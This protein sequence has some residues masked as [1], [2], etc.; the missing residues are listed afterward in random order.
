M[1]FTE[2][3]LKPTLLRAL[4]RMKYQEL[5]PIQEQTLPYILAGQD[6]LATAET[7]AGKTGYP[8]TLRSSSSSLFH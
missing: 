4:E 3:D 1:K 5:T 2:L 8:G 7:G 6:L